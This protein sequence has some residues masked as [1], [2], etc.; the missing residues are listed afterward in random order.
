MGK[1][2]KWTD[3]QDARLL[4]LIQ[5]RSAE[6]VA[7]ELGL[8]RPQVEYRLTFLRARGRTVVTRGR[9]YSGNPRA[10]LTGARKAY[11]ERVAGLVKV[12]VQ[13][14]ELGVSE[15]ILRR[16]L[17]MLKL[18]VWRPAQKWTQE[19]DAVLRAWAGKE[20]LHDLARRV[21]RSRSSVAGHARFLRLDVSW[22]A[23][24]DAA[25][26]ERV[27]RLCGE[28]CSVP[29]IARREGVSTGAVRW[30]VKR[31][32][33]RV[34]DARKRAPRPQQPGRSAPRE[35]K[36]KQKAAKREALAK[37]AARV[38]V[39][40]SVSYCPECKCPVTATTWPAHAA[41]TGHRWAA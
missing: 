16:W 15:R 9:G 30:I 40:G 23:P 2:H 11:L 10:E 21:G 29:E 34:V 4:E 6:D 38:K 31:L 27:T 7:A 33:L 25:R 18:P 32:G 24:P 39:R 5:T 19:Q 22:S 14:E 20:S 8:R 17:R 26:D 41:R 12:R 37:V 3:E 35:R 1:H 13:A 36:P 28:G